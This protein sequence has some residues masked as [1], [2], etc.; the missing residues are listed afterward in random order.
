MTRF[1]GDPIFIQGITPPI[2]RRS[3]LVL[4]TRSELV[5]IILTLI[6]LSV[7]AHELI[8]MRGV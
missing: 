5:L 8:G 2:V 4:P 7:V 1:E 6:A 3:G